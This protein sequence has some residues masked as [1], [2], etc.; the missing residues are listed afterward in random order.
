MLTTM[1]LLGVLL[2]F[3]LGLCASLVEDYWYWRGVNRGP[4]DDGTADRGG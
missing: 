2:G 3:A 1:F 4:A